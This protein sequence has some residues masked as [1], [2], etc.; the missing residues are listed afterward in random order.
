MYVLGMNNKR[1]ELRP[2]AGRV[3][4]AAPIGQPRRDRRR[5]AMVS[6]LSRWV[7]DVRM[8]S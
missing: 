7:L 6:V 3:A 8:H 1:G 4:R 5:R 2:A